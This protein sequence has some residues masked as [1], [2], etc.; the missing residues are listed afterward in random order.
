MNLPDEIKTIDDVYEVTTVVNKSSFIA[1]VY[2]INSEEEFKSHLTK[3][4]NKYY[5][6]SHHCYAYKLVNGN[7][8]Y[9]DAGEPNGTAGV[10]ILNAI[11]HFNLVN[12]LVIVSRIFGGIK[13]G[14]GPLGKAYYQ[15]AFDVLNRSNINSRHLFQKV[16]ILSEIKQ[17]SHIHRILN[18]HKSIIINS[19]YQEKFS[20]S[21]LIKSTEIDS[22]SQMLL[23]LGKSKII[24]TTQ[25]EFVYK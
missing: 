18:N 14:V 9:S 19:E 17:I 20:L 10:R 7:F 22:V 25:P 13:L 2:P 21:C 1:Q 24:L 5:D 6:A 3:A 12:Q 11:E 16:Q 4:K 23:N 15:S 8:R